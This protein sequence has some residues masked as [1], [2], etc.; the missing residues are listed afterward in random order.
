MKDHKEN[1]LPYPDR[2]LKAVLHTW[3]DRRDD[4]THDTPI[5]LTCLACAKATWLLENF[6]N[7]L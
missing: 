3:E 1:F 6:C 5:Y 4:V 7:S 2:K